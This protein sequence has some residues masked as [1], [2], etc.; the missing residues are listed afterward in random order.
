MIPYVKCFLSYIYSVRCCRFN[1]SFFFLERCQ[2][3]FQIIFLIQKI[4][5]PVYASFPKNILLKQQTISCIDLKAFCIFSRT[6]TTGLMFVKITQ[7][8][9]LNGY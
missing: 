6:E 8:I 5:F 9:S 3:T 1:S 7:Q 4:T 2:R